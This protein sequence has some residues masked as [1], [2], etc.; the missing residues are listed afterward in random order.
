MRKRIDWIKIINDLISVGETDLSIAKA[1]G[2]SQPAINRYKNG[3]SEDPAHAVGESLI[4]L[5]DKLVVR[6]RPAAGDA[7]GDEAI[8]GEVTAP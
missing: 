4:E 5:H 1:V 8:N 7:L 3:K 2:S 6:T